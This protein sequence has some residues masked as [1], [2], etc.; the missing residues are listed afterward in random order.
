MRWFNTMALLALAGTILAAAESK[1]HT[2]RFGKKDAGKVP[3][4]WKTDQTHK[5]KHSSIWKVVAD[6]TGPG[7]TGYVLAQTA[8]SPDRV[9]NLC[10]VQHGKYQDVELRVAFKAIRG[11]NDQGG[12][13]VWRYRDANNYYIA[14][15]NPLEKNYRVYKVVAG[16]RKELKR[17]ERLGVK[18]GEWHRLTIRQKGDHIECF[19]DGKKM[20]DARDRTFPKA[21]K[22]GLWSKSDAQTHFDKFQVTDLGK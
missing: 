17:K 5:G 19:L 12:G 18:V 15:M 21:G 8:K 6:K 14:R 11:E 20:L 10:V 9:F 7:K 13:F 4:G 16:V 22:V 1:T 3:A 2:F